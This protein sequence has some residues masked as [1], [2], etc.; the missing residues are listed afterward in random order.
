VVVG[1]LIVTV[2]PTTKFV[3]LIVSA[4][5]VITPYVTLA[6]LTLL[7]V[8]AGWAAASCARPRD[9][10]AT[11]AQMTA[12]GAQISRSIKQRPQTI[13]RT[14]ARSLRDQLG[15]HGPV[16]SALNTG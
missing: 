4:W 6:G 11:N 7:I 13:G 5:L 14:T 3:P 15:P 16:M 1:L 2:A 12:T 10:A 8:G 9:S